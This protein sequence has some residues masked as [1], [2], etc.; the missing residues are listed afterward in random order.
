MVRYF[1][2]SCDQHFGQHRQHLWQTL[3]DQIDNICDNHI[4]DK[5]DIVFDKHFFTRSTTFLTNMFYK[6]NNF[7]DEHFFTRS[8]TIL[9]YTFLQDWQHFWQFFTRSTPFVT[10]T[11]WQDRQHFWQILFSDQFCSNFKTFTSYQKEFSF[12]KCLVY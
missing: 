10:N 11:F 9:T 5:I 4:F 2:N 1:D 3:F 7:C 12:Y 8:T 6:I